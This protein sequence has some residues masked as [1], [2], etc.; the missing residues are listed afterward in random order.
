MTCPWQST[1][2]F[3]HCEAELCSW[4]VQPGNTWTNVAFLVAAYLIWR[5]RTPE[6]VADNNLYVMS[7]LLVC[8]GSVTF[9]ATG[10][11]WG[12]VM[13][14]YT[15]LVFSMLFLSSALERFLHLSRR[16]TYL[17]Y[18]VGLVLSLTYPLFMKSGK[19]F[20]G[21]QIL[22]AMV[23]EIILKKRRENALEP[24]NF[25]WAVT[26]FGFAF[27]C[28]YV[29]VNRIVCDPHNHIFPMHGGWHFLSATS[30]YF[31]YLATTSRTRSKDTVS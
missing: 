25:R 8:A 31:M 23:V 24:K 15:M 17:L 12:A 19:P 3:K 26:A 10:T 13:D 21:L 11:P 1:S 27:A 29:D 6:T 2:E 22:G 20:F 5:R 28:F 14:M 16:Q 30:I 7:S 4:I 18:G 9:H